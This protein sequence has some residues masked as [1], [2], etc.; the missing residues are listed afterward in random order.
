MY[1]PEQGERYSVNGSGWIFYK[2]A[3]N[4][5]FDFQIALEGEI[6]EGSLEYYDKSALLDFQSISLNKVEL[7][8][9]GLTFRGMGRFNDWVSVTAYF[10]I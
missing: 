10:V 8:E 2:N 1:E 9:E 6:I 5:S 4:A 3:I 7:R